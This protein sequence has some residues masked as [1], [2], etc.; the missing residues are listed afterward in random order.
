M[1]V[2]TM[3]ALAITCAGLAICLPVEQSG[4]IG[5]FGGSLLAGAVVVGMQVINK[6]KKRFPACKHNDQDVD[7]AEMLSNL[8]LGLEMAGGALCFTAAELII[9][10]APQRLLLNAAV[11]A[12]AATGFV[13][14]C[15]G[16]ADLANYNPTRLRHDEDTTSEE[17]QDQGTTPTYRNIK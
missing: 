2:R 8:D 1:R 4:I 13:E 15:K 6:M 14:A 12:L 17:E 16:V 3:T 10:Q 11:G 9:T 5:L 7:E